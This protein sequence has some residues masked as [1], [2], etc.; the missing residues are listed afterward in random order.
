MMIR[1]FGQPI[2]CEIIPSGFLLQIR[3]RF[4]V[5]VSRVAR[6][7]FQRLVTR[8]AGAA[9]VGSDLLDLLSSLF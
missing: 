7:A 5:G 3:R 6:R 9:R 4:A 1:L 2:W 8:H